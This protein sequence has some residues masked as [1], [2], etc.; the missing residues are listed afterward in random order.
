MLWHTEEQNQTEDG[1]PKRNIKSLRGILRL[2][3]EYDCEDENGIIFIDWKKFNSHERDL[4][5]YLESIYRGKYQ[6]KQ[7]KNIKI[8]IDYEERKL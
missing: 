3:V 8:Q 1:N 5:R 7:L 6:R 2:E 4:I